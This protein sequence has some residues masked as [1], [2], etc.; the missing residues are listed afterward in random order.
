[1]TPLTDI[2]EMRLS[3]V[4]EGGKDYFFK[5]SFEAMAAIGSP[6]EIV[7]TFSTIHGAGVQSL[8]DKVSQTRLKLTQHM[9]NSIF[10]RPGDEMLTAAM[11]VM[12]CCYKGEG[13]LSPLIGE[14]KG[15]SNCVVY[16]PGVITKQDIIV[17]AQD[18]MQHGV[19]G[20]AKIRKLQRHEA[21]EYSNEFKA[22]D[23][24]T[25]ARNHFG[26]SRDD[27]ANLT[28]TEFTLLLAAKYPDQK[29]FTKEEYDSVADDF[30]A[31]QAHRREMAAQQH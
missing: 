25:A 27:A 7:S 9:M 12:H 26:M 11:R 18:L 21:N 16:R 23:Y 24:I 19:I 1:M 31:Q 30:L 15:W 5:P 13:E 22:I 8:I 2:G 4:K 29:G 10:N 3:E 17:L 14:W 20:K 28:M 6:E